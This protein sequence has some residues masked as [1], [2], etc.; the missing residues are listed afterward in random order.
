MP[1][2]LGELA[3]EA[4]AALDHA[5]TEAAPVHAFETKLV[6]GDPRI[7]LLAEDRTA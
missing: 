5:R 2:V 4:R 3:A 1:Q 7:C 6:E